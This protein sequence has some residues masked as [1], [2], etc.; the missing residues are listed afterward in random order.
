MPLPI[1]SPKNND[2]ASLFSTG[3][4]SRPIKV[5]IDLSLD[6]ENEVASYLL[7]LVKREGVQEL[8][9][10]GVLGDEFDGEDFSGCG[11]GVPGVWLRVEDETQTPDASDGV[12]FWGWDSSSPPGSA[13]VWGNAI[14]VARSDTRDTTYQ[15]LPFEVAAR[16]RWLDM[17]AL[18]AASAIGGDI[19]VTNRPYLLSNSLFHKDRAI[20]CTPE[21][22]LEFIG[23]YLRVTGRPTFSCVPDGGTLS[24]GSRWGFYETAAREAVAVGSVIDPDAALTDAR[25]KLFL[26]YAI[27]RYL[28]ST[29]WARDDL[30]AA[31]NGSPL[32]SDG[33]T[34]HHHAG[35]ALM[36]LLGACDATAALVNERLQVGVSDVSTAWQRKDFANAVKKQ[37]PKIWQCFEAAGGAKWVALLNLLRNTVHSVPLLPY[38]D[39]SSLSSPMVLTG[40]AKVSELEA[41]VK[42]LHSTNIDHAVW[43]TPSGDLALLPGPLID[44][45]VRETAVVLDAVVAG[46][47]KELPLNST[48]QS[49]GTDQLQ[50]GR[51]AVL[52]LGLQ[53]RSTVEG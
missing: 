35:T 13:A 38:P 50:L 7:A 49:P 33:T 47:L 42:D 5:V 36:Y 3:D 37:A 6:I 27:T 15:H 22:A 53:A 41:A 45:L 21:Q 43:Q 48:V 34:A 1:L 46:L 26:P 10:L 40:Q 11:P 39:S 2:R 51:L 17:A 23:M 8:R 12:A 31:L 20:P 30:H 28:T 24:A 25:S 14:R 32:R 9:Y 16:Q 4:S 29:L 52:Q 19:L 18:R 44:V